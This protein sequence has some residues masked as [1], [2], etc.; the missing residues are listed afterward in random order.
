MTISELLPRNPATKTGELE[1]SDTPL[2]RFYKLRRGDMGFWW[3]VTQFATQITTSTLNTPREMFRIVP[4]RL[5]ITN[6][7]A[8]VGR[9]LPID[10]VDV[11]HGDRYKEAFEC[12]LASLRPLITI[13]PQNIRISTFPVTSCSHIF[14]HGSLR[15]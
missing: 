7:P 9:W 8:N 11:R 3:P 10:G 15:R 2:V 13:N 1:G 14:Q 5:D 12:L 4:Y 6:T